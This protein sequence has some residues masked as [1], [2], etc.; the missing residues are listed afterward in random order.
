MHLWT[1]GLWGKY[2]YTGLKAI[3][4]TMEKSTFFNKST[5]VLLYFCTSGLPEYLTTGQLD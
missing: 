3:Y 5:S 2:I 4:S 1:T